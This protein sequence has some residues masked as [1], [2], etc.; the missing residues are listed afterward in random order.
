MTEGV[1]Y[2]LH[3]SIPSSVLRSCAHSSREPVRCQELTEKMF[4][5][6]GVYVTIPL[7]VTGGLDTMAVGA[8][9]DAFGYF[10]VQ[11]VLLAV[12]GY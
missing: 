7:A 1:Y 12:L 9:H 8:P 4:P 5:G 3:Y 2:N 10:F 6:A 11:E